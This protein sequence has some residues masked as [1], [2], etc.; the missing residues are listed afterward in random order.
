MCTAV[1][2][3][4]RD[5][6]FGRNL[7]LDFHYQESVTITP[8]NYPLSFRCLN[9]VPTHYAIIGIAT[10]DHDYPLYY[11]ATNEH[12]L[13]MAGLNF[14]NEAVYQAK[15][16]ASTNVAPFELMPWV[17]AQCKTVKEAK[18]LLENA[19]ICKLSY[20]V[21]Y[22]LTPLHWLIADKQESIAVEPLSNGLKISDNPI[23]ILTNSPPFE[24]HLYN[25]ANYLNLTAD[26]PDSRFSNMLKPIPYSRGMGALGLPGDLSSASRFVRA[27]F[28]KFN[29]I[30]KEEEWSSVSQFFHILSSVEQQNGCCKTEHGYEKTIYS[31]CCNTDKG[32]YYFTTY[33]NR[34]IRAVDLRHCDLNGHELQTYN[35]ESSQSIEYI[36]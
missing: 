21:D 28:V 5:H 10:V 35:I 4:S 25:L 7:D 14:P 19:N 6:Y 22:P 16:P 20:S 15:M 2:F 36:N 3:K 17:L 30:C 13:S 23:G 18:V 29:S 33:E 27:A 8:R 32:M 12:G 1:S 11:D 34:Q 31:S 26:M 24:Y 9:T